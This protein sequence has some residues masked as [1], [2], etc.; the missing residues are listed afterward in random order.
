MIDIMA[1][2]QLPI[3]NIMIMDGKIVRGETLFASR[4]R[5]YIPAVRN[6]GIKTI[7]DFRT[8]DHTHRF[9]EMV[10][11]Q[12]LVYEHYPI[13]SC[14]TSD[15]DIL[16]S[17]PDL[18]ARLDEGDCYISCQQGRHR[19]DI[20]MALYYL[21]HDTLNEPPILFGHQKADGTFRCDDIM[22]RS[23][24]ILHSLT[25]EDRTALRLLDD[26]ETIFIN[27]RKALLMRNRNS[28]C[29]IH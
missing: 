3:L 28:M 7:I 27:K 23:R 18:F 8:A 14:R 22:R 12:G 9:Q 13:D 15:R 2:Q 6:A 16:N 26:Y 19:T 24:S 5:R 4:N 11:R 25:M 17:L 1:I 29:V 20:V 10:V 21:F